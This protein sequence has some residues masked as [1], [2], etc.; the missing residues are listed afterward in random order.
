MHLFGPSLLLLE[1]LAFSDSSTWNID[2]PDTL[3]SWE[4]ACV[5]IPCLYRIPAYSKS[6]DSLTLYHNFTYDSITKNFIGNILYSSKNATTVPERVQFLGDHKSNCSLRIEP[7][8]VT[9]S[10]QLGLRM[11]SG[12]QKWMEKI[13]LS[14]SE[15]PPPLHIQLPPEI[16][17]RREVTLTC[18]LKFACP[19][20]QI[21]LQWSMES[22]AVTSTSLGTKILST[23]SKLTFQPHW[24]HNGQNLTCQLKDLTTEKILS[25]ETVRLNVKHRPKLEIKLEE[26][27][28][29]VG[30]SVTITCHVISSNP[31]HQ[32]ISWFKDNTELRVQEPTR[33]TLSAVSKEDSGKYHCHTFNDVGSSDSKDVVLQV[34]FTPEPSTVQINPL[35]AKEKEMVEL[36]CISVA[37]PPPTNYTW[38]HNGKKLEGRTEKNFQIPNIL[39]SNAGNY[40]C[41]AENILGSGKVGSEAELDVQYPPKGVT[42]V[43]QNPTPIREGDDVTL[44]CNYNSSN[45]GVTEYKWSTHVFKNESFPNVSMIRKVPW[46][47]KTIA[48]EACNGWCS[49]SPSIKLDVHYAPRDVKVLKISPQTEIHSGNLVLLQCNFSSSRPTDVHFFWKKNGGLLEE[50]RNLS[51]A[52]IS[53]EDAGHYSCSVNNSIGETTSAAWILQVLYAPRRLRVSIDPQDRVMEGKNAVLTCESDAN[54]SVSQYTWFD[55]N[56]QKLYQAGQM[57]KLEPTKVEHSGA[58]RCQVANRLGVSMSPPSTLTVYYSPKTMGK[59][60]AV[61]IGAC[62]SILILAVWGVKLCR[63]WKKIRSQQELQENSSG[64]SFFVKNKKVRRVCL[65]EGPH[66]QGCYNPAMEDG[67][68]YAALRFPVGETDIPGAGDVGTSASAP[69]M[70]DMV[71]YSVV[72][73]RHVG[74]Y[75]NVPSA[76]PED[77]EGIHYSELVHFGTGERPPAPEGVE[78]VT[79]KP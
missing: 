18:S 45:P 71:T 77:E 32:N 59:R 38:Y 76:V 30:E 22:P 50:G 26:A 62:L 5:W 48:C 10:G 4:G 13:N 21:K 42:T 34:Q 19:G 31:E 37:C 49:K 60:A 24:T 64:Q 67:I 58:Y 16:Q 39:L 46:N 52:S 27:T 54:P 73:K 11:V 41:S 36:T 69:D 43:I 55:W 47:A 14:V 29:K 74:D 1:Y 3:Y 33:L 63:R 6:L 17:E 12:T 7:V 79:L 57:L 9:D 72:Q 20:Y 78:Y 15:K 56:N 61:G 40:S 75:E 68:S 35:P 66:S 8:H 2:H 51:F 70:E 53:P 23:E 44:V 65:S 25:Q 28:V